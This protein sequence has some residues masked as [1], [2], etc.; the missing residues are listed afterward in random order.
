MAP[1]PQPSTVTHSLVGILELGDQ[2]AALFQVNG[3]TRRVHLGEAIGS[4]GWMLVEVGNQEAIIRRN[5]E[6]R[7]IYIGQNF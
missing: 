3:V 6:V 2:S 4:A 5:G 7:S 1:I